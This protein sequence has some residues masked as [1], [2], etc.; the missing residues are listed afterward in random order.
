MKRLTKDR[1]WAAVL[2][3]AVFLQGLMLLLLDS[4]SPLAVAQCLLVT[5]VL[6]FATLEAWLR[7]GQ[8]NHRV[9]MVLVMTAL[10]GLG[11]I[12]GWWVDFGCQEAPEWLRLGLAPPRPWHFTDKV[13]S[14]MTLGMLIGGIPPSLFVTRC[15][16]LARG[17]PRRFFST[18]ILG[19][20]AMIVGMIV[21]NRLYGKAFGRFLGSYVAG[22][23]LAMLVGMALGMVAGM[24]L[25]E[26]LMGLR[27]WREGRVGLE[28]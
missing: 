20:A 21:F 5:G 16:R 24:W 26:A 3:G 15:A 7:R 27:P 19:N 22:A 1:V 11:M 12:L 17:N 10:G 4:F 6:A 18:H 23:H 25:G 9:D 14:F 13:L 8:L 28:E 2:G